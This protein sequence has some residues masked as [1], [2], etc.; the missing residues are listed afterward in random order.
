MDGIEE[1][2]Q[3]ECQGEQS[4]PIAT[5]NGKEKM[6]VALVL[7]KSVNI[8]TF[9]LLILK[10]TATITRTLQTTSRCSYPSDYIRIKFPIKIV[11]NALENK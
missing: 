7:T 4:A 9:I 8:L 2:K 6:D 5:P 10:A 3:D 11:E 1:L